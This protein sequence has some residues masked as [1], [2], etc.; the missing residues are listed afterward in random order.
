[1]L[2]LLFRIGDDRYAL[3]AL[4]IAEV[5]P[6][7]GVKGIPQA[8]AGV[9][10][11]ID[12]HGSPVPLI[13]LSQLALGRPA[14]R[15]LSTRIV[16]VHYAD[17]KGTKKHLLGLL[18]EGAT[19]TMRRDTADFVASGVGNDPAPYLG[20]VASDEHGMIQW[21]NIDKLLPPMVRDQLFKQPVSAS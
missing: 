9:A 18:A 12:Y 8:P 2:F 21:V 16:L 19:E 15:R 1:M 14:R 3:D 5:L 11:I 13:D 10:G 7:V 20:P 6:V 17:Q 4:Q